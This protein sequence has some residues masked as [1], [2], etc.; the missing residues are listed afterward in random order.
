MNKAQQ[1]TKDLNSYLKLVISHLRD[2]V[3]KHVVLFLINKTIQAI[4]GV[5][6]DMHEGVEGVDAGQL[7]VGQF[8]T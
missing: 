4:D 8:V 3:P 5:D 1:L 6:V 7:Q 2:L